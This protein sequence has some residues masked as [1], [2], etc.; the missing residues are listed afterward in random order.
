MQ[1][2]VTRCVH[3]LTRCVCSALALL[4]SSTILFSERIRYTHVYV[5]MYLLYPM[6]ALMHSN[7]HIYTRASLY[8]QV[9]VRATR[10]PRCEGRCRC[11]CCVI[12]LCRLLQ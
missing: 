6:S 5:C 2:V 3:L 1:P 11:Y 9:P 12:M 8:L 10:S 7:T 4:K